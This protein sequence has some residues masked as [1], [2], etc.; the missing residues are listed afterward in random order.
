MIDAALAGREYLV[1]AQFTAADVVMGS[2]LAWC[3]MMGAIGGDVPNVG[4]YLAR[5]SARPAAQRALT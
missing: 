3:Q 4:A 1:G 2:T 5:V